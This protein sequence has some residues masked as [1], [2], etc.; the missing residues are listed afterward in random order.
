MVKTASPLTSTSNNNLPRPSGPVIGPP[1]RHARGQVKELFSTTGTG[2][3]LKGLKTKLGR[4][5]GG[6]NG[7]GG[8]E[9]LRR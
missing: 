4:N 8:F 5:S 6:A 3:L 1:R 2:D 7:A 9:S